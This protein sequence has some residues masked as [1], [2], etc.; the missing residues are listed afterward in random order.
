MRARLIGRR[1]RRPSVR[2]HDIVREH[3]RFHFFAT[4][5]GQHSA[6]DLDARA[7]HLAA[8]FDHLLAL[9]GI[10]DDITVFERQIVFVEDGANALA[11]AT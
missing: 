3:P 8:L 5:V 1:I 4:D 10:V 11:P 9:H 2:L 7:E 6:V